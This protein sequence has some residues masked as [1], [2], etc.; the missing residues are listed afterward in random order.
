MTIKILEAKIDLLNS[1]SNTP[2]EPWKTLNGKLVGQ[3]GNYHI[4]SAYGKW[5][6]HKVCNEGG[7]VSD[8]IQFGTKREVASAIDVLIN[9][10]CD[11]IAKSQMA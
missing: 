2:M 7:A 5:C 8:I 4:Y 6:V 3:I 11:K 9:S 1:V 10:K